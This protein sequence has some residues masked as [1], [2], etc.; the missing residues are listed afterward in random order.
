MSV[1]IDEMNWKLIVILII[2]SAIVAFIGDI[3]GMRVGKKRISLFGMRPKYTSSV[4]T[5][6]SGVLITLFTLVVLA[7][8]SETIRT[9]IFSMKFVQTQITELTS[10]L[11]DNRTDLQSMEIQ[12]LE[13]QQVLINK[14]VQLA[15]VES[16]LE[17]N[18]ALL[19]VIQQELD[20]AKQ[21]REAALAETDILRTEKQEL[22]SRV[23]SLRLEADTLK[24]GLEYIR[25]G[26]IVVFAGE[27]VGQTV[28]APEDSKN[29]Q[30]ALD[31]LVE[32]ARETLALRTGDDPGS[33]DL[34]LEEGSVSKID[35]CFTGDGGRVIARLIAAENAV[36]GEPVPVKV[37]TF[38]ST[39]I[40]G[41]GEI[42]AENEIENGLSATE[43]E[44]RLYTILRDVNRK[45]QDD[46]VLPDPLRGT[47]GNLGAAEFFE[48]VD[49]ITESPAP[50]LVSVKTSQDIH[51]EGPVRVEIIIR[52]VEP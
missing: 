33:I 24:E 9:A 34:S 52:P 4:I 22:E 20:Q 19:E 48:A 46:G 6:V 39:M 43:A 18:R 15:A 51:T 41:A 27:L 32:S 25:G 23:Q 17:E 16:K 26:R 14:Q 40:Y 5:V 2:V 1:W 50:V 30:K 21:E 12:L 42:L 38:P 45:A 47:V 29:P 3:V 13:N 36:L 7:F 49:K 44:E 35:D 37:R 28:V 11:Q 10:Q 31:K 8:T